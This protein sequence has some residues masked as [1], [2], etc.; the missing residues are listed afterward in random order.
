MVTGSLKIKTGGLIDAAQKPRFEV[1]LCVFDHVC[2]EG[3]T[4]CFVYDELDKRFV[5]WGP[6]SELLLFN[7]G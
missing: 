3:K 1:W 7:T 4:Y 6:N 2:D 5:G